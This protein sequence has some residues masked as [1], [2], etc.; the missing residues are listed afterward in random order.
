MTSTGVQQVFFNHIK[1]ILPHHLS[2][3]DEVANLLNISNDSAYRR[4]RGDKPLTFEEVQKLCVHFNISLDSIFHLD[5]DNYIFSGK[6]VSPS[7]FHF[8]LYLKKMLADLEMVK[9]FEKAEF[10]FV[11]KDIPLFHHFQIPEL[12]AFKFFFFMKTILSYPDLAFEKFSVDKVPESLKT[13]GKK[14]ADTY[15]QVSSTEIWNVHGIETTLQQIDYYR[16]SRAFEKKEDILYIY[17]CMH[18][19]LT[20]VEKQA[21]AG[22]KYPLF[23]NESW[24]GASYRLYNN[25]V[26]IGDN[27]ILV[28]APVFRIT[29]INHSVINYMSTRNTEFCDHIFQSIQN[30]MQRSLQISSTGEKERARFFNEMRENIDRRK[31]ITLNMNY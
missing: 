20:H 14:V 17:D 19:I 9:S 11:N 6:L 16:D 22:K 3:V 15:C 30:T 31:K 28:D 29:F 13:I 1:S 27:T 5:T 21:T 4:M 7:T 10:Y 24:G 25:E 8:E 12:A 23:L 2:I 26:F 18:Q